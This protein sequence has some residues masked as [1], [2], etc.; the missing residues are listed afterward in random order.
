MCGCVYVRAWNGYG[1]AV[2]SLCISAACVLPGAD[3][4]LTRRAAVWGVCWCGVRGLSE[5]FGM[6]VGSS[7][8]LCAAASCCWNE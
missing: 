2:F 4:V 1:L 8:V 5:A 3:G 7:V 6:A